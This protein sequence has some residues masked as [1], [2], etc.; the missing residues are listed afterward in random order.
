MKRKQQVPKQ[1]V[2]IEEMKS[3]LEK[4]DQEIR[5]KQRD[6]DKM[7]GEIE[8]LTDKIC[9]MLDMDDLAKADEKLRKMEKELEKDSETL[10]TKFALLMERLEGEGKFER[11]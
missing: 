1:E 5:F 9:T 6:K 11:E 3:G 2:N 4:I 8:G 7:E 10:N